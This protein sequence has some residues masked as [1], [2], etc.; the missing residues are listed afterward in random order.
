[1]TKLQYLYLDSKQAFLANHSPSAYGAHAT[2]TPNHIS[3]LTLTDPHPTKN[4][5]I[6]TQTPLH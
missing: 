5:S 1:M 6:R 3:T 2:L 4:T